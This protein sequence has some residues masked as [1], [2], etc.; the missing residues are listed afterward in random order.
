MTAEDQKVFSQCLDKALSGKKAKDINKYLNHI[1]EKLAKTQSLGP[2]SSIALTKEADEC[3]QN[4]A[5]AK[6]AR[7]ITQQNQ[8]IKQQGKQIEL[9][10]IKLDYLKA[11]GNLQLA[12]QAFDK[13]CFNHKV[14]TV[15]ETCYSDYE[16]IAKAQSDHTQFYNYLYDAGLDICFTL[17]TAGF[18]KILQEVGDVGVES[19]KTMTKA[20]AKGLAKLKADKAA[21]V[22]KNADPKIVRDA[23]IEGVEDLGQMAVSKYIFGPTPKPANKVK[24][25]P[26]AFKLNYYTPITNKVSELIQHLTKVNDDLDKYFNARKDIVLND[27]GEMKTA[28]NDSI[29]KLVATTTRVKKLSLK[30]CDK[31]EYHMMRSLL[32]T[33]IKGLDPSFECEPLKREDLPKRHLFKT[34]QADLD[35]MKENKEGDVNINLMKHDYAYIPNE[36][37]DV[38]TND[39]PEFISCKESNFGDINDA[40]DSDFWKALVKYNIIKET[41]GITKDENWMTEDNTKH[42]MMWAHA[43]RV[44]K[45]YPFKK[46]L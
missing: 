4:V 37:K 34:S 9:N 6:N 21:Q 32:S 12:I 1:K 22:V 28:L 41:P 42:L 7:Q 18:S 40:F 38:N 2:N 20:I 39:D 35:E 10:S 14:W 13:R 33:I 26:A 25:D 15:Y 16:A 23:L 17:L 24:I 30:V 3:K 5:T 19:T 29:S 45:D 36:D 44:P 27:N 43:Y 11:F 31:L 8:V 46:E